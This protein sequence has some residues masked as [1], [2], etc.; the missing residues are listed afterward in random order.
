MAQKIKIQKLDMKKI[1]MVKNF[2]II[3]NKNNNQLQ[4]LNKFKSLHQKNL[5]LFKNLILNKQIKK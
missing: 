4:M 2:K 3:Q 1:N 5:M